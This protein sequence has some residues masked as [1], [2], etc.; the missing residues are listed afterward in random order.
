MDIQGYRD[1]GPDT[2]IHVYID[3]RIQGSMGT[4]IQG[5]RDTRIDGYR[6]T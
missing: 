1:K 4:W 5:Y 6:Y 3:A 2:W